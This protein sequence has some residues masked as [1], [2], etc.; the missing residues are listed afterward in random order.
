MLVTAASFV[1]LLGMLGL[2]VDV[3]RVYIA[4]HEAQDFADLAAVAACRHLDGK[5]T[6]IDEANAEVVTAA[7]TNKWNFATSTFVTAMRTVEFST[8]QNGPW[9]AN[10]TNAG[11]ATPYAN[12]A[13]VRVTVTPSVNLAFLPAVGT[14]LTQQVTGMAV[15]GVTQQSFPAG[16]YLPFTPFAHNAADPNFGFKLGEEYAFHWPGNVNNKNN[17]C[18]GDTVDST[19]APNWPVFND[20]D[21]VGGSVRGYF[22][23]QS[24]AAI[25]DAIIGEKQT[26]PVAV[27]DQ[28]TLTNGNKQAEA[29][30]L[31]DRASYD[32]DQTNY[33]WTDTNPGVAPPYTGNGMREVILPVNDMNIVNGQ[34]HV[35]GF[36]AFLLYPSYANN[37]NKAWCAIYM[38]SKTEGGDPNGGN[39]YNKGGAY[40]VRLMQ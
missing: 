10:P 16:G 34:V 2:S 19:G 14:A 18:H 37:G 17:A 36:A 29:S 4:K 24:A 40:T 22:E 11:G 7:T 39:P 35:I 20:S 1:M 31:T 8:T 28:I 33:M 21:Q 26:D 38:G 9:Q 3:G 25:R 27:G 32:T 13:F 30:A 12:Y 6:G 23:L 15:A 5:Q